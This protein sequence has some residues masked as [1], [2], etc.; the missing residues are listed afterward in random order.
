M[1][2][3]RLIEVRVGPNGEVEVEAHG[4]KGKECKN[5]TKWLE[6]ALGKEGDVRKKAEWYLTNSSSLRRQRKVGIDG[7][8]LCG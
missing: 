7:A 8:K 2:G 5:S 4:F 1:A 3:K 6:E